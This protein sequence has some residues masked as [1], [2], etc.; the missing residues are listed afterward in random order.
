[1][2]CNIEFLQRF[3]DTDLEGADLKAFQDHLRDCPACRGRVERHQKREQ[4]IRD[5][6]RGGLPLG[7][8]APR[9]M[10]RLSIESG[11]QASFPYLKLIVGLLILAGLMVAWLGSPSPSWIN[12]K[13]LREPLPE[14]KS[15][16]GFPAIIAGVGG[17]MLDSSHLKPGMRFTLPA[18]ATAQVVGQAQ[19]QPEPG[20]EIMIQ[21]RSQGVFTREALMWQNGEAEL[22]FKLV[23][24][25]KVVVGESSITIRGTVIRIKGE[26]KGNVQIQ[27]MRGA[28][29][30]T[31]PQG[32][33][34]LPIGVVVELPAARPIPEKP[35]VVEPASDPV[36]PTSVGSEPDVVSPPA[37]TTTSPET[38]S[39][40][41]NPSGVSSVTIQGNPYED[42]PVSVPG[43]R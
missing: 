41:T 28:A 27:L 32:V 33:R 31:T 12:E 23:K 8:L 20:Q 24:P 16:P 34:P 9:V 19:F 43:S 2:P 26:A 7:T 15:E 21:G 13:P 39:A 18:Q 38:G 29:D 36:Q 4:T 14:G 30:L 17:C 25:F 5:R 10:P 6:V 22:S 42:S 1:M 35:P 3:L 40:S 11:P 37:T